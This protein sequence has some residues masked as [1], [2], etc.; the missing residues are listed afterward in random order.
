MQTL[1]EGRYMSVLSCERAG[2]GGG[3]DGLEGQRLGGQGMEGL[4]EA[5]QCVS[6]SLTFCR[7]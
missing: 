6:S 7:A 5:F 1:G 2:D 4:E 3:G